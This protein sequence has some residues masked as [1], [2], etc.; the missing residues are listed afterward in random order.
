M[1]L[2]PLEFIP[3]MRDYLWG[4]RRLAETLDKPVA[5]GQTAAESWEV[6]DHGR[7]QSVVAA[8]PLAGKTLGELVQQSGDALLGRPAERFPLLLKYLDCHRDLSVQVHPDDAYAQQLDPPDLGKT[9]AWYIVDAQPGSKL[10]AGLREGVDRAALAAAMA[11]GRTDEVLHVIEPQPGDCVF[12][13]AGTVHALG[14]GLLVAEIQQASDTTFRLFDWNRV[15]PDGQPRQLHIEQA[16]DVSDYSRGP[17]RLQEPH[18]AGDGWQRL[19]QCDKFTLLRATGAGRFDVAATQGRPRFSIL[20]V[21]QGTAEVQWRGG[22]LSLA[23][24]R[25]LLVPASCGDYTVETTAEDTTVLRV[26]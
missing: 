24:G 23:T 21:P 13:P 6:V 2:Y 17:V 11:A 15:G 26:A 25:S 4:G 8:G 5:A 18:A 20:T 16:L 14:A 19:V 10:Y 12:I 22:R 1:T 3:V 7:D 9:E